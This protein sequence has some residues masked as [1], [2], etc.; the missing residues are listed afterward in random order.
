MADDQ[1]KLVHD[2]VLL[3]NNFV[4]QLNN[5]FIRLDVVKECERNRF[6]TSF[7]IRLLLEDL[8]EAVPPTAELFS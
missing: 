3:S 8:G 5:H 1:A 7:V 4:T 2:L 6:F